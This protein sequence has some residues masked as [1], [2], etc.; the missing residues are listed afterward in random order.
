MGGPL[1]LLEGEYT[2]NGTSILTGTGSCPATERWEKFSRN[3]STAPPVAV[4]KRSV[5]PVRVVRAVCA[6]GVCQSL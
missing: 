2:M 5:R 6:H 1:S 3:A 4:S